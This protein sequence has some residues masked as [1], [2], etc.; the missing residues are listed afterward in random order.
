M[1]SGR[2]QRSILSI[3]LVAPSLLGFAGPDSPA[4]RVIRKAVVF[5]TD[6]SSGQPGIVRA[7]NGDLLVAFYSGTDYSATNIQIARSNDGG[8][9]WQK[10]QSVVEG[11]Y[12][13]VGI[14]R[15][16]DGTILLPFFQEFFKEPC[17]QVRRY[18][19]YVYR[20]NDNGRTWQGDGPIQV[21]MREPIPY[22]HILELQDGRLLLPVWGAW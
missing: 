22:G 4:F 21:E 1:L 13:E 12:S 20:S 9:H 15:L 19:T 18:E 16:R 5:E 7:P 3:A 14:T 8:A 10:A 6:T 17:C 2:M 11:A